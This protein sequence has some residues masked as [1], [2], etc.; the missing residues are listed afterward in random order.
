MQASLL[1]LNDA[2]IAGQEPCLLQGST[3]RIPVNSIEC[4]GHT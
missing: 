2:G 1:A 4:T 3:V